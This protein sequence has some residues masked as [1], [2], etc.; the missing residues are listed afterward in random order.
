M[1]ALIRPDD[2][3]LV[4]SYKLLNS[5]EGANVMKNYKVWHLRRHHPGSC[6]SPMLITHCQSPAAITRVDHPASV[7]R[8]DHP[9]K[10]AKEDEEDQGQ[11]VL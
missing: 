4:E 5:R 10:L 1:V 2:L 6:R 7:T 3:N 8:V 9:V 11:L